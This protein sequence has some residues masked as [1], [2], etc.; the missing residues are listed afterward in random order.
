MCF[1]K[2][3][4]K[5]HHGLMVLAIIVAVAA[6]AAGAYVLFTKVLKDKFCKK[7]VEGE[8]EFE[9]IADEADV[10]CEVAVEEEA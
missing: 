1:Y 5:S 4:K 9:K 2:K 3:K 8:C 7:K 6:A 10:V